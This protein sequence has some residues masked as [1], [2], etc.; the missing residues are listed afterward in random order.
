MKLLFFISSLRGGGAE[1]VMAVLTDEFAK[2]GHKITLA[3]M[4]GIPPFYTLNPRIEVKYFPFEKKNNLYG[5]VKNRLS[6][7][8]FIRKLSKE[9]K[10][11]VIVS[12]IYPMNTNVLLATR[13]L[14]IPVIASE[15]NTLNK[16]MSMF[17]KF[18]RFYI[19]KWADK[20]TILTQ[21][22][23][24]YLGKRLKNKIVMPNPLPFT[25]IEVYNEDRENVILAVGSIKRYIHKGFDNLVEIWSHIADKHPDWQLHIAGESDEKSLNYL[26]SIEENQNV[27]NKIHY[28]GQVKNM[29]SLLQRSSIFILSS[30]WEGFPMVLIEA[31]SQGCA[32]ISYDLISGPREIITFDFDGVLVKNQDKTKMMKELTVLMENKEKQKYLAKNAIKSINRFSIEKITDRW[33]EIF[34]DVNRF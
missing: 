11:D 15:H 3:I 5:K 23:F 4:D 27:R 30:R 21:H 14:G 32:C 22:D 2:R 34:N 29:T 13:F 20:L 10:P 18:Q 16:R 19:S 6:L 33:E 7:L 9:E 8:S 31:M 17:E 26:N 24:E 28:L 25:P 12:F 1:R